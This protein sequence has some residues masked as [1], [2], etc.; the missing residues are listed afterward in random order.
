MGGRASSESAPVIYT[1]EQ[2]YFQNVRTHFDT[3]HHLTIQW[4]LENLP[5]AADAL[6]ATIRNTLPAEAKLADA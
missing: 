2:A 3:N 6:A 4:T 1:C 5:A